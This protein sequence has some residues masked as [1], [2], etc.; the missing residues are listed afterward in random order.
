MLEQPSSVDAERALL[1]GLLQR[2]ET[3]SDI[4]DILGP[5]DFFRPEHGKLFSLLCKMNADGIAID[6]VTVANQMQVGGEADG[7]GGASYVSDLTAHAPST[8]NLDQY[9]GIISHARILRD[10]HALGNKVSDLAK[11]RPEDADDLFNLVQAS[12]NKIGEDRDKQGWR[13]VSV[14]VDEE[15]TRLEKIEDQAGGISGTS[16]GFFDLNDLLSGLQKTDLIVLAA[17][18]GMGKTAFALNIAQNAAVIDNAIVGV[19]S[20]EMG[21]GQ[22]VS[23]LLCSEARVD[24]KKLKSGGLTED[25]WN[26]ID[27][28]SEVLRKAKIHIIDTPALTISDV[29]A[30]AR[31]LAAE[32]KGLDLIIIDYLQLMRGD[33]PR[34]NREQQISSIS[35]GLKALAKE[36]DIPVIALSQLNRGVESRQDKRPM[37]SDL[38]E[39]GAIEQDADI[40][41]F[42]YRDEYYNEDSEDKGLAEVIVAKQRSG[43][44]GKVKLVWQ[45]K[46]TRFDNL[47]RDGK[48]D[49]LGL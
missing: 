25:D 13:Q 4:S 40:I 12:L 11:L 19:F 46:Y 9:A 6:L 28:A 38:R 2:S 43:S 17:R 5:T 23:R 45:G 30:K 24:G 21:K 44:T 47:V 1:G 29:R 10:F 26:R 8:G 27:L 37:L 36:L 22:L 42:I 16:T 14:I 20:L 49:D 48:P 41:M 34:T 18:P 31:R 3:I 39:S 35:R 15:L 33:E 32:Q 7:Y